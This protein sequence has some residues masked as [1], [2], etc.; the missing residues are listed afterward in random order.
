MMFVFSL[1]A[2]T[3]E[4]ILSFEEQL[5]GLYDMLLSIA[6]MFYAWKNRIVCSTQ[7]A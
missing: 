1:I 7:I 6:A 4:T 5:N 3:L 2:V